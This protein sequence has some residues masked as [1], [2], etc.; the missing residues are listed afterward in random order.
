MPTPEFAFARSRTPLLCVPTT[1][2]FLTRIL[3]TTAIMYENLAFGLATGR[4][5]NVVVCALQQTEICLHW[6]KGCCPYGGEYCLYQ[7]AAVL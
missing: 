4:E 1:P 2:Y 7:V 6:Q 5:W 3:P